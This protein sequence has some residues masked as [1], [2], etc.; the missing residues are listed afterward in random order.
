M[1]FI[2][3]VGDRGS[4]KTNLLTALMKHEFDTFGR[5]IVGN[6]QINFPS[7]FMTFDEVRKLPPEIRDST[8]GLDELGLGADSYE[9]FSKANKEISELI[10]ELRKLH[11][12]AWYT[13]QRFNL[14]AKRLRDQ[15]DGFIL[16]EDLDRVNMVRSDGTPVAT[17]REVCD[18]M[19]RATFY[20]GSF[21]F[22]VSRVFDGKPFWHLYNT[23][24]KVKPATAVS[25]KE[26]EDGDEDYDLPPIRTRRSRTI[27]KRA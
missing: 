12:K 21:K 18:G 2:A 11:A 24:E 8:I 20:N 13:V 14:I 17:H 25:P 15:T 22:V 6:Y 7:K 1:E 23:D 27:V 19:F 10:F 4:G 26:V 3:I 16:M 5:R 9:F